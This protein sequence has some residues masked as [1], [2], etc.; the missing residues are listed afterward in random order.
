MLTIAFL[1]VQRATSP[2]PGT[3]PEGDSDL[4]KVRTSIESEAAD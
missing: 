2:E 1:A 3:E 4:G